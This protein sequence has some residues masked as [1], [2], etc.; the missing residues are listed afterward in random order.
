MGLQKRWEVYVLLDEERAI[1]YVG[2]TG[3]P[4]QRRTAHLYSVDKN[5]WIY[6]TY[7]VYDSREE[8]AAAER[9]LIVSLTTGGERLQNHI[10]REIVDEVRKRRERGM[11]ERKD[12]SYYVARLKVILEMREQIGK[13][14]KE[15]DIALLEMILRKLEEY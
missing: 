8:A 11:S 10:G 9:E 4:E 13:Q 7:Q 12:S 1:Q 14:L 2:C 5:M 3:N 15:V 6:E